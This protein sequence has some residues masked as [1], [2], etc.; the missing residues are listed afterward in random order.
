[1][2]LRLCCPD[3]EHEALDYQFVPVLTKCDPWS[4]ALASVGSVALLGSSE[5]LCFT[6]RKTSFF[7]TNFVNLVTDQV[8]SL[9]ETPN[10]CVGPT[11]SKYIGLQGTWTPLITRVVLFFSLCHFYDSVILY[12][13][14]SC[15]KFSL[16]VEV[17]KLILHQFIILYYKK[18]GLTEL[19]SKN[20]SYSGAFI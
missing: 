11:C 20:Q 15:L 8:S 5:W 6:W 14:V 10:P 7:L 2:L 3:T 19:I 12:I 1:M 18:R 17:N 4:H 9:P 16:K 13:F